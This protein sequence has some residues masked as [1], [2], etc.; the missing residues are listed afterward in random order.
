MSGEVAQ[1]LIGR[2]NLIHTHE[3]RAEKSH[4]LYVI[5]SIYY[6]IKTVIEQQIGAK[7]WTKLTKQY[8]SQIK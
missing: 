7:Y 1:D 5:L 4:S 8:I 3:E 6:I 2:S